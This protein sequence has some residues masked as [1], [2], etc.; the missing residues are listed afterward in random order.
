MAKRCNE[1]RVMME[2]VRWGQRGARI[3][4]ISP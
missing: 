4:S 2:A 3:N 1:K